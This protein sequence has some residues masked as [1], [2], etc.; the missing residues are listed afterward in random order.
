MY[1]KKMIAM[2]L[3]LSMLAASLAGCAGG[4]DD[5]DDDWTITMANDVSVVWV[6]SAWDPIIPNLNAGEMCDVIISAMTKTDAR[7]EVVDF[8]S[9][10]YTS[11][12]G[13][14]GGTGVASITDVSELNATGVKIGLQSGTT[15]DLYAQ[16]N[17][18]D[19]TISAFGTF[20]EVVLALEDGNVQYIMG[21]APVLELEGTLMDTFSDENFGFAVRE[22][23]SELLAA[24]NVAIA[25]VIASGEYDVIY[26]NWFSDTNRLADDSTADTATVYPT[27]T[28]GSTLTSVLESGQLKVCTDPEY[29]P[30]EYKDE[31]DNIIGFDADMA[32]AV[33]D[34]IAAHYMDADNAASK[35]VIKLGVIYDTT[36]DLAN[37]APA[38]TFARDHAFADLN[39]ANPDYDFQMVYANTNCK[40]A[41]GALAAQS[42]ADAGVVAVAGAACSG[43]S[44]GANSVLSQAGIPMISFAS[45]S[46]A[47]SDAVNYPHFYR[48][49][50]SDAF[51][52]DAL[53]D[54]ISA[55]GLRNT[56]ILS[57]TNAYGA[58][59]GDSF[60]A[61]FEAKEG[62]QICTRVPYSTDGFSAST[63]SD[64]VTTV[65]S[66]AADGTAC[67]SVL[68]ASYS[69]D[70]AQMLAGL[71]SAQSMIPAF[72]PDGMA[73]E[74][75]V[76]SLT[77]FTN[78]TEILHG[79]VATKPAGTG[80]SSGDF[81]QRCADDS[82]CSE[83]I[84][85]SELYDAVTML[86]A[87]AMMEDG[88]NMGTHV[89]MVGSGNGHTGASGTHVFSSNG[90]VPGEVYTYSVGTFYDVPTYGTYY[91]IERTW[92]VEGGIANAPLPAMEV[93]I[94][95]MGD[96]TSPDISAL[97]PS[98]VASYSIAEQLA[99]W[100]AWNQGVRFTFITADSACGNGDLATTN[101]QVLVDAGV[102]GV[103]GAACSG[104][105]INAN[106]PLSDAG[107]P[108]ISYASTAAILSDDAIHPL[109]WRVVTSDAEQSQALADV[110]D[111]NGHGA[112]IAIVNGVDTYNAGLANGFKNAIEAKGHTLCAQSTYDAASG[113]A[114]MYNDA[115]QTMQ[116]NNCDSV[117]IFAYNEDGAGL[118]QELAT[119]MWSG[120]IYGGDGIGSVTLG[121]SLDDKSILDG[122]ITTNPGLPTWA[123]SDAGG[124]PNPV[125]DV[126]P[127]IWAMFAKAMVMAD[128]DGDGVNDTEVEVSIP[129]GQFAEQA[130]DASVIMALSAFASLAGATKAQAITST[131]ANFNGASG[132]I[133]FN[134]NGEL[135][136]SGF[137]IG[138][139]SAT[140]SSVGYECTK[141]WQLGVITEQTSS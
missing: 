63:V 118:I 16:D 13:V 36:A 29:P 56:A 14:I 52:G 68:L 121:D 80:V 21:D 12:Q 31:D 4:D 55:A 65:L 62:H 98:F 50:P 46:P 113:S 90:D 112:N 137:C 67:D 99:N 105:S 34:E 37:F 83:G 15:S 103:V 136:G 134:A 132:V 53:A 100:I 57:M 135:E 139:F 30:F 2:M 119:D 88:K 116:D 59:V 115:T 109:F 3:T 9:A 35:K 123:V 25:A 97:W 129:K 44:I 104:A 114:S 138:T 82:D 60:A 124:D 101:A 20:P 5:E 33:S 81:P 49:V 71:R 64:A 106:K 10:Y 85:T 79:L 86:G 22:D 126:F 47:L 1:N 70:G 24:L 140:A 39:A 38:F 102:W 69:P 78:Q 130:F 95:F 141:A 127:D 40:E 128:T 117:A 74:A 94:G 28:E 18:V 110:V 84:F 54:V 77:E 120:Q 96:I 92:T 51:Q 93:K 87:A 42:V 107:I 111:A 32:H 108:M 26:G 6:E 122:I 125:Q 91:N 11:T 133:Q 61:A 66:G 23:S 48:V 75:V 73:G 45:T 41:D 72:G 131:G 76:N 17:L 58:G 89:P 43:A 19:A 7:D 8:T 27:P